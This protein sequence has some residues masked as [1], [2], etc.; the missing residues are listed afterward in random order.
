MK[1]RACTAIIFAL[2]SMVPAGSWAM[3]KH[4]DTFFHENRSSFD[5]S[6]I[7]DR[8]FA[9]LMAV[10]QSVE[11]SENFKTLRDNSALEISSRIFLNHLDSLRLRERRLF[12]EPH[13][14]QTLKEMLKRGIKDTRTVAYWKA[15]ENHSG[16]DQPEA[17]RIRISH[18]DGSVSWI[19]AIDDEGSLSLNLFSPNYENSSD[20]LSERESNTGKIA[21]RLSRFAPAELFKF[22]QHFREHAEQL[23]FYGAVDNPSLL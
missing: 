21:P 1:A 15:G 6:T 9:H 11:S 12:E 5:A 8:A 3:Q 4:P 7:H 20:Y 16:D 13:H 23:P 10:L 22:D 18:Y 2:A 17:Y 19:Y 14:Y